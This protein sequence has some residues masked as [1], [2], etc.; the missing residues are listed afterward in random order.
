MEAAPFTVEQ[1]IRFS[2]TDPAG[3]VYFP[4]YFDFCNGVMED[5]YTRALGIDYARLIFVERHAT[6]IVHAECDFFAPSKM[7]D[8]LSLTLIL[9][10]VG[11]TSIDISIHGHAKGVLRLE[12]KIVTVYMNLDTQKPEDVPAGMRARFDVYQ[13]ACA[14]WVPPA[15]PGAAA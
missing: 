2:H 5:W 12:A 14:G 7:G 4:N 6:P 1:Q 9:R 13:N 3:I 10:K 8:R 11:R 15:R